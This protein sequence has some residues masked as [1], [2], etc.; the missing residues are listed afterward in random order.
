M[1]EEPKDSQQTLP[2]SQEGEVRAPAEILFA[3]QAE[4]LRVQNR[5]EEAIAVLKEGLEKNP[6]LSS[7]EAVVGKMLLGEGDAGGG[8]NRTGKGLRHH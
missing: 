5:L 7:G 8:Q 1:S 3:V 2:A 4:G 6:G